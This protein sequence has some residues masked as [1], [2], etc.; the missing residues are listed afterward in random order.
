MRCSSEC[1]RCMF[2]R[3]PF[4]FLWWPK[5]SFKISVLYALSGSWLEYD[6]Y[7]LNLIIFQFQWMILTYFPLC[8]WMFQEPYIFCIFK[9]EFI[10]CTFQW[11]QLGEKMSFGEYSTNSTSGKCRM[12]FYKCCI[13]AYLFYDKK[14]VW[15]QE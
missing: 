6:V 11:L 5:Y 14:M 3:R 4:L 7:K 13:Q 9:T 15:T 12:L 8:I 2:V 1:D 10:R